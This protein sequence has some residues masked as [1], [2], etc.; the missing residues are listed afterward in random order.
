VRDRLSLWTPSVESFLRRPTL[1]C[2]ITAFSE[3]RLVNALRQWATWGRDCD[4]FYVAIGLPVATMDDLFNETAEAI[5]LRARAATLLQQY[6]LPASRLLAVR[7]PVSW[8]SELPAGTYDRWQFFR[9]LS[10]V[11]GDEPRTASVF[12]AEFTLFVPDDAYVVPINAAYLLD[13]P[14]VQL[15]NQLATPLL[16]GQVLRVPPPDG[17][18]IE[19]EPRLFVSAGGGILWNRLAF[20]LFRNLVRSQEHTAFA[21]TAAHDVLLA[22]AFRFYGVRVIDTADPSGAD[23]QHVL[24]PELITQVGL[25][26]SIAPVYTVLR[27]RPSLRGPYAIATMSFVFA[28]LDTLEA[29]DV[30]HRAVTGRAPV[31]APSL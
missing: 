27:G 30:M 14:E 7:A 17:E 5:H 19:P 13:G 26:S 1:L 20:R 8:K 9:E 28:G 6:D 24:N 2:I 23:R 22:D 12:H 31:H 18:E 21:N 4:D 16:M 11:M 15:Y 10:R 3:T 29:M 25:N